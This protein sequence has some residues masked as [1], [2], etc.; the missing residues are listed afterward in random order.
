MTA[1][2]R[3]GAMRAIHR[4]P[5]GRRPASRLY[6]RLLM[7]L[8]P[9][10]TATTYFGAT[11]R[12]D[13][14]DFLQ[15]TIFHH[16]TWEPN[17][18]SALEALARPGDVVADIGANIGYYTLLL[19]KRVGPSGHVVAIEAHPRF[20]AIVRENVALNGFGNV[21]VEQL[22]VSDRTG[23]LILHE[24]PRSNSG[25]TTTRERR[26]LA[27]SFSVPARSL[28]EILSADEIARVSLIK[29]DIEG[30]EGPVLRELLDRIDLFGPRLAIA[31]EVN[32]ED[33]AG[34]AD[35]F[36]RFLA[37]GFRAVRMENDYR[38]ETLEAEAAAPRVEI[39]A[40]PEGVADI[41]FVRGQALP[42]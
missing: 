5:F 6:N 27:P 3:N 28:F 8:A 37:A 23:E 25:S 14:R 31:V 26:G 20:A 11:M 42:R 15:A 1:I 39:V 10:R 32:P 13:M 38:W 4:L 19:A 33:D 40:L 16:G 29:I 21:R 34:W 36:A 18:S 35:I 17:V 30:A 7:H 22:A 2:R 24:G 12:V 9:H 41:L